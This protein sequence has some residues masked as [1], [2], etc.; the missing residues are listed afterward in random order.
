MK[1]PAWQIQAGDIVDLE[2]DMYAD[3][4]H[5]HVILES[6]Y[7][8]VVGAERETIKCVRIDFDGFDS[9]GFPA[10]H[11]IKVVGRRPIDA[12]EG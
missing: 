10:H 12:G 9:V 4:A 2:G 5:R 11:F 6:E 8:T 1:L 3:P 7:V